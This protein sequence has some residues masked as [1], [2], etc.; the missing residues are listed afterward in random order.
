MKP[1]ILI[2]STM[3]KIILL[4]LMTIPM[5]SFAQEKVTWNYPVRPGT[6]EWKQLNSFKERLD[7]FNIPDDILQEI[8]TD[9]LVK[10]CL[11][12]PWWILITSRDDN[13]EG[14]DFLKSVFNGFRELEK[15]KDAG[16][17]LI[18]EYEKMNPEER[19]ELK[20]L[21]EK[22]KYSYQYIFIETLLSGAV[23]QENLSQQ[24]LKELLVVTT[25]IFRDKTKPELKYSLMNLSSTGFLLAN[26]LRK[27]HNEVLLEI[28]DEYSNFE[29]FITKGFTGDAELLIRIQDLAE[30]YYKSL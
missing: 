23:V 14:Y 25:S 27:Y 4:Y 3:R 7:A 12:Y 19:M 10:T 5:I 29:Q 24:D 9:E 2:L 20:T 1:K 15:R 30:E 22:G 11:E 8:T 26:I 13:Q 21:I 17:A 16:K 28:R 6:E 18:K